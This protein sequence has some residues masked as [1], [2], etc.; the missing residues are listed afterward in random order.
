MRA[1]MMN[2][3]RATHLAWR[4]G[5]TLTIFLTLACLIGTLFVPTAHAAGPVEVTLTVK[6]LFVSDGL[7]TPPSDAF[8]YQL[9][10]QT[11]SAPMPAGSNSEGYTFTVAGSRGVQIGPI[12][13][14]TAGI[15]T[16]T[17][18]CVADDIPGYTIDRRTYTIE[19]Y[20]SDEPEAAVLIYF[21]GDKASELVF[22]HIYGTLPIDPGAEVE[23]TVNGNPATAGTF[24][25]RLVAEN[26]NNPMP[27]G[28]VDGV[29][30][31]T[32]I[33]SGQA[34]FGDWTYTSEGTYRYTISEINDGLA[35]YTYDTAVY[36][37]TDV[38][39][40]VDGQLVVNR[41]ITK[42]TGETVSQIRFVNTY[43]SPGRLTP[44]GSGSGGGGSTGKPNPPVDGPKTGDFSNPLLWITLIAVS[45]VL[46]MLII[47]LG[48]RSSKQ[49]KR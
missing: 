49:A 2:Q 36:T 22:E 25:F 19:V 31:I 16:Y 47:L 9:T 26:P 21:N 44:P 18:R 11:P 37:I 35:G 46:L 34:Q 10:P 48:R 40:A 5:R 45:G 29:K 41:T 20:V 8:S 28:S 33:G 43:T 30:T 6:Q 39:T 17:L 32:I 42:N 15:Y 3:K 4:A 14:N 27:A 7:S 24:T 12:S 23:K 13:F 1:G 38:V